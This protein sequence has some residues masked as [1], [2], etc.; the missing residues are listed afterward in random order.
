MARRI[1]ITLAIALFCL[2]NPT[3]EIPR[4]EELVERF[5]GDLVAFVDIEGAEDPTLDSDVTQI[6]RVISITWCISSPRDDEQKFTR[7]KLMAK[8]RT[9]AF[10]FP[11]S[12]ED[13]KLL[14]K[15]ELPPDNYELILEVE[16]KEGVLY[17]SNTFGGDGPKSGTIAL[18]PRGAFDEEAIWGNRLAKEALRW[19]DFASPKGE[20]WYSRAW[21][22][23]KDNY[24]LLGYFHDRGVAYSYG[25]KDTPDFFYRKLSLSRKASGRNA[26]SWTDYA[27][28]F[29]R[30][31]FSVGLESREIDWEDPKYA[32][33]SWA[34]VDCSGFVQ[35]A[36]YAAGYRFPG[37]LYEGNI[38]NGEFNRFGG[39]MSVMEFKEY[40]KPITTSQNLRLE[41][42]K[43]GD[44]IIYPPQEAHNRIPHIGIVSR[45]SYTKGAIYVISAYPQFEGGLRMVREHRATDYG[46]TYEIWR[47]NPPKD[48]NEVHSR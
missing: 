36:A 42:V 9:H 40:A 14:N 44:L 22:E 24:D 41:N 35:R 15:S 17:R 20:A 10:E 21:F 13:R 26:L 38:G 6:S 43:R 3:P 2:A 46:E 34:G 28:D 12:L 33:P 11:I 8:G 4:G 27:A 37:K 7:A 29:K 48:G 39:E 5:P 18:I 47:L 1:P 23:S 16:G 32:P 30:D 19:V 31:S 45:I 25:G